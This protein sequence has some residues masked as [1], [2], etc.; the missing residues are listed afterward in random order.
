MSSAAFP[1][2]HLY[3]LGAAVD[4]LDTSLQIQVLSHLQDKA[5]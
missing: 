1:C 3:Q 5:L 2:A 4:D